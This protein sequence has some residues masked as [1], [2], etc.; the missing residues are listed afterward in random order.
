MTEQHMPDL[1]VVIITLEN[2]EHIRKIIHRLQEQTVRERLEIL[3]V[4]P[5]TVHLALEADELEM[6]HSFQVIEL[7]E[8]RSSAKAR[9]AAVQNSKGAIIAFAEDHCFPEPSWAE[10]LIT[11]HREPYA[12]VGALMINGNP[13]TPISWA[14]FFL[15]FGTWANPEAT[16]VMPTLPQ[17]N[18]TYKR[19]DLLDFGDQLETMLAAEILMQWR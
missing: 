7:R 1:S 9:L 16:G 15:N 19:K 10:S 8:L 2:F 13:K 6:F 5:S 11:S 4:T 14:S 3:I 12:G 17:H 18:S